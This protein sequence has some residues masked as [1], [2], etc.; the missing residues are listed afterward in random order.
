MSA[1]TRTRP[2]S[3]DNFVVL[4]DLT[5]DGRILLGKNSD[6]PEYE[7]QPLRYEPRRTATAGE[8]FQ[9]RYVQVPSVAQTYAHLGAAPYWCWG[10]EMGIN[11]YGLAIGNE[12]TFSRD[13]AE[14][15]AAHQRGQSPAHGIVGMELLRLGL[16]RARTA[17]EAIEVMT[18]LLETYGQWGAAKIGEADD[19]GSYDNSFVIADAQQAWVLESAGQRWVAQR[20]DHGSWAIS[21]E[22]SIR[23][24]WTKAS[25][26]LTTHAAAQGWPGV[27]EKVDFTRAYVDPTTPRQVSHIRVRRALDLLSQVRPGTFNRETAIGILSD[28]YEGTFLDGPFFNAASPDFLSICMHSSPGEFTW[29][30]TASSALFGME[31]EDVVL[32]RMWWAPVTPCTSIYLPVYVAAGRVPALLSDAGGADTS[33]TSA[34]PATAEDFAEESL[35]W[36]FQALLDWVKGDVDAS[37]YPERQPRVRQRFDQ[38]QEQ[39]FAEAEQVETR[40]RELI[41]S[42]QREEAARILGDLTERCAN[43]AR[44]LA[45]EFIGVPAARTTAMAG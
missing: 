45:R 41:A 24:E 43:Q 11:E 2:M 19:E 6:R 5:S 10:Y 21:N 14:K 44:D 30:N 31:T 9:L 26:D 16:E 42:G 18:A 33:G 8:P 40:A 39:W 28:H 35:W 20:I 37:A 25:S 3:C 1:T 34:E 13:L 36:W 22:P 15:A 17:E 27:G 12:A 32:G 7:T 29:G 38:A 4:P 23:D